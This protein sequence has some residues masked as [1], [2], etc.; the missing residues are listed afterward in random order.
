MQTRTPPSAV[1]PQALAVP[2]PGKGVPH[3]IPTPPRHAPC[4]FDRKP[5]R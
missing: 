4:R 3:R 5:W 1:L 2:M